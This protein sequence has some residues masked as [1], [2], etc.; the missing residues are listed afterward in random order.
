MTTGS[1]L[2]AD[3][4]ALLAS[5]VCWGLIVAA[6]GLWLALPR[7]GPTFRSFAAILGV[8]GMVM[9]AI[10]L[11]RFEPAGHQFLFWLLAGAAVVS[12]AAA[13]S[14]SNPVYTA[15]WFA[16]SLL[17]VAGLFV[18]Q[19]AQFL[20][21]ATIM[22]YAG[23]IVVTFLFVL[24][25]AQA[26]GRAVYDRVSW[27]GS[28][29]PLSILAAAVLVILVAWATASP[30]TPSQGGSNVLA[31]EH[32]AGLGTQLFARHLIAVEL[33]GSLLLVALVGAIAIVM[34]GNQQPLGEPNSA[35]G[36]PE[37]DR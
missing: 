29:G 20:G 19:H 32:M 28:A 8:A 33:V 7:R 4:S 35:A 34:H 6:F 30:G 15:I 3:L 21:V 16:A 37:D 14:A 11:P 17:G 27:A 23:A 26:D 36:N 1:A 9:V 13:V 10:G 12:S 24:M 31:E 22:V 2:P 5:P 18:L 25:L